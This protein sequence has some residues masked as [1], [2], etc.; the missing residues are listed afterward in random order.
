MT[1][2]GPL[3]PGL[4]HPDAI[5]PETAAI[6][7]MLVAQMKQAPGIEIT[8]AVKV[9][10]DQR[11]GTKSRPAPVF[12]DRAETRVIPGPGGDL[13]LRIIRAAEPRGVFLHMHGGGWVIGGADLQDPMLEKY[14]DACGA[15]MVSVEYRLAP[16]NPYPAAPDDCEAAAVW[17]VENAARELGSE[18]IVIGG[19]SAGA[20]LA[21]VTALRMRDRHGYRGF[22][23]ANLVFGVYDVAQTPSARRWN[24]QLI[25][26]PEALRWVA[27][28]FVPESRRQD[29]D[30]SPVHADLS[31]MPPALFT[32]GTLD[33]L[34]DDSLFMHARWIAAGNQAELAVYPGGAHG[35]IAFPGEIAAAANRRCDD[36][37]KGIAG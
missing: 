29:P 11:T 8:G 27:D 26:S 18:R 36:F 28:A 32:I 35:F 25:L 31:D 10:E 1:D 15:T 19:E 2:T 37:L 13:S 22:R 21:A 16:E 34:L 4:F 24:Q 20:H 7:E 12:S 3:D 14:A 30:V 6:N 23:A 33:P 9:R 5:A 17:V